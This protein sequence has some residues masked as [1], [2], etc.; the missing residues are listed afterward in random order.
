MN[1]SLDSALIRFPRHAEEGQ[2]PDFD[3]RIK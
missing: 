2:H 1:E 3:D